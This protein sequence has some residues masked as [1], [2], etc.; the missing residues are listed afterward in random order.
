MTYAVAS[1]AFDSSMP[2]AAPCAVNAPNSLDQL[3][4]IFLNVVGKSGDRLQLRVNMGNAL[5]ALFDALL[6]YHAERDEESNYILSDNLTSSN[7]TLPTDVQKSILSRCAEACSSGRYQK[8]Q[9]GKK[10]DFSLAVV[11]PVLLRGR[12][13]EAFVAVV[14]LVL[15]NEGTLVNILQFAAINFTLWH[16]LHDASLVEREAQVASAVVEILEKLAAQPDVPQA[17]AVLVNYLKEHFQ[18]DLVAIGLVHRDQAPCRLAAISGVSLINRHGELPRCL[19]SA[20]DETIVRGTISV[21]PSA[22]DAERHA[23]MT[24]KKLCSV[25]GSSAAIG[26]PLSRPDGT[27]FGAIIA[28]GADA[29]LH[30]ESTHQFLRGAAEPLVPTLDLLQRKQSGILGRLTKQ[31]SKRVRTA[32]GKIAIGTFVAVVVLLFIPWPYRIGCECQIQPV[33]RRFAEAPYA[34]ILEQTIAGPGDVVS[35]GQVLARMDGREIRCELSGLQA[36]Y[37]RAV[38]Q[39]DAA[40][41]GHHVGAEQIASLE[42]QRLDQKMEILRHRQEN[43]EIASPCDGVILS[44]DLRQVQGAPLTTGQVLYEIAPLEKMIVEVE[45]P[46]EEIAYVEPGQEVAM[47][48][49]AFPRDAQEGK[50]VKIHP[51]ME[52]REHRAIFIAELELAN[53]NDIYRPGMR[54]QAKI[55]TAA[56][57]LGWNLFHRS[58]EWVL[59]HL[60]F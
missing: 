29:L 24:Y 56:H 26:M 42:M 8:L 59:F 2:A 27:P 23:L 54:G 47:H 1:M 13:P 12:A 4:E 14:P 25:A 46:E 9:F 45:V 58:Y 60:G 16:V 50:I 20:L 17:T 33:I 53:K 57:P 3:P 19:E 6:L 49:E 32:A 34:G 38:K 48:F 28:C 36:E 35:K 37:D 40:M 21:W 43:L 10:G 55:S 7:D 18:A 39:H 52:M 30:K 44:G 51:K 41:S 11:M 5:E 22:N 31:M 15:H